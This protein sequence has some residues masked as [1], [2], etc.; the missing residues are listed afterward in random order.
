MNKSFLS[1]Q[2]AKRYSN[3]IKNKLYFLI[4]VLFH[5]FN[6]L[7]TGSPIIVEPISVE[8]TIEAHRPQP[9]HD[10]FPERTN[11]NNKADDGI[12][13][14]EQNQLQLRRLYDTSVTCN[15]GSSIGYY[16]RLSANYSRNWVIY[17]EGG[18][19]CGNE[20]SCQLRWQRTPELMSSSNWPP[21]RTGE[22]RQIF[23]I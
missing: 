22:Y 18:G 6:F 1:R 4:L 5:I 2:S 16:V 17:L 7:A 14:A 8:T 11:N 3:P 19:F 20:D 9:A 12:T 15:D 23:H 21:S 13:A 10:S